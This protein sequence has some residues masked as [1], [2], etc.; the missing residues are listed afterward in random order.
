MGCK[1]FWILELFDKDGKEVEYND[2]DGP[3]IFG[4][5]TESFDIIERIIDEGF[6]YNELRI[7][8]IEG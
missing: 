6:I 5:I 3:D 7:R 2:G 8:W 1:A 4:N